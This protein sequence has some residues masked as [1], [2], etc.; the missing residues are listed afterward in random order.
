M[1]GRDLVTDHVF[2]PDDSVFQYKWDVPVSYTLSVNS[3][4]Q[5]SWLYHENS[6]CKSFSQLLFV[7][8][9]KFCDICKK[10]KKDADV[11]DFYLLS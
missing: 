9:N 8:S 7:G 11:S 5:M 3:T 6:T 1:C 10:E 4:V 2:S